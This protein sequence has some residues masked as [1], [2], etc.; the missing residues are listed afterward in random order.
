MKIRY[1]LI[2]LT[3]RGQKE[4]EKE[5]EKEKKTTRSLPRH[6]EKSC[7]SEFIT[8]KTF[9]KFLSFVTTMVLFF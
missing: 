5:K 7:F 3:I 2:Y 4:K 6:R 8:E 9:N 1:V